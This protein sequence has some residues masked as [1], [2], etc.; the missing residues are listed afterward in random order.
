MLQVRARPTWEEFN[1]LPENPS[2]Y[3]RS[4][5]H[6]MYVRASEQ[7]RRLLHVPAFCRWTP[8]LCNIGLGEDTGIVALQSLLA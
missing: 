2:S 4:F 6:S 3:A 1:A 5:P 8:L 7:L